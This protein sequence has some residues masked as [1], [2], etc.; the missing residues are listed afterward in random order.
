MNG[1]CPG[2]RLSNV[3]LN[4]V[5]RILAEELQDI[6]VKVNST[7]P[8]WVRTDIGGPNAILPLE[9]GARAII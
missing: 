4:A 7:C 9:E 3:A 8:S 5:T 2:Y 6:C 1:R